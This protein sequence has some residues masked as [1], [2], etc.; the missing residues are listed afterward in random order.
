MTDSG[1]SQSTIAEFKYPPN[2]LVRCYNP[3]KGHGFVLNF[4]MCNTAVAWALYPTSIKVENND[5]CFHKNYLDRFPSLETFIYAFPII[6][7][8]F[9]RHHDSAHDNVLTKHED[10]QRGNRGDDERGKDDRR[11]V[12]LLELVEVD[13]QR[14]HGFL[15]AYQ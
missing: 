14:P 4:S 3:S 10:D 6:R 11:I 15:L 5:P 8:F 9:H 7:L 2:N 13:H 1:V 12:R